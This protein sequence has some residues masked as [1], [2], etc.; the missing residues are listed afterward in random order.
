MF[1]ETCYDLNDKEKSIKEKDESKIKIGSLKF[2]TNLTKRNHLKECIKR[3]NPIEKPNYIK[4]DN[5]I[6]NFIPKEELEQLIA[7]FH[8][9]N[10][11]TTTIHTKINKQS[12]LIIHFDSPKPQ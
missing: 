5:P 7:T 10:P 2:D 6:E 9:K 11:K 3:K 12:I 8:K 1:A 4:T